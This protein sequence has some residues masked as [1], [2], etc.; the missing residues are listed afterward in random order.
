MLQITSIVTIIGKEKKTLGIV[1]ELPL[2]S[3][4]TTGKYDRHDV[5]VNP[6]C[7]KPVEDGPPSYTIVSSSKKQSH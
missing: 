5:T 3:K 7:F 6:R 1:I 2:L 4:D